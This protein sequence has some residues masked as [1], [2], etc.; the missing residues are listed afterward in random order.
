MDKVK[1]ATI[2]L[3]ISF[4]LI[5]ISVYINFNEHRTFNS[6]RVIDEIDNNYAQVSISIEKNSI[7]NFNN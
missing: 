2:L 4:L 6:A 7:N 5:S 3:M 1:I